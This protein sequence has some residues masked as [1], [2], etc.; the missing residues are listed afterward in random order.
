[1]PDHIDPWRFTDL[2]K[3]ISGA[4]PLEALPRIRN[5]V[6]ESQGIVRFNLEFFRD[7]HSRACLRG[8]IEAELVLECQRCLE[9]L[10]WPVKSNVSLAFVEGLDEANR[11]PDALDPVL[12]DE[13]LVTLKDLVEDELLLSLP[14]VPMHP[15][16]NC[17]PQVDAHHLTGNRDESIRKNPFAALA[18]LKRNDK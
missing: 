6:A 18:E 13:G 9:K 8:W 1:L 14:Q 17:V 16:G 11:L 15:P 7:K 4:Y 3:R 10:V 2:Q 12:V 5:C